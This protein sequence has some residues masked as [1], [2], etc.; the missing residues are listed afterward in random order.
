VQLAPGARVAGSALQVAAST[1]QL[2]DS[3]KLTGF[4]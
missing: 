3:G 1:R 2:A 4:G